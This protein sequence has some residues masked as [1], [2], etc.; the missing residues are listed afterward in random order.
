M[1]ISDLLRRFRFHGVPGAPAAA[2][3]PTDRTRDIE[4]ELAP[5]FAALDHVQR[6]AIELRATAQGDAAR[7]R[8]E[9]VRDCRRIVSEAR[10][11]AGA[12]QAAAAATCLAQMQRERGALLAAGREEADRTARVAAQRMP[13]LV[14]QAVRRVFSSVSADGAVLSAPGGS[15]TATVTR[16]GGDCPP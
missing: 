4:A 8:S 10:A 2:A 15:Q 14:D 11:D 7:R 3:V 1:A 12:A 5:V 13:D 9:T 6:R 16:G